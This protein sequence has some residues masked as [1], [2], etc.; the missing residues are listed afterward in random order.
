MS[1][2]KKDREDAGVEAV[3]LSPV[4]VIVEAE[5]LRIL[6]ETMILRRKM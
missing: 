2:E 3:G 6:R 1:D 5:R 4:A